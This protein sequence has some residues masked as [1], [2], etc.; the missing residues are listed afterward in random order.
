MFVPNQQFTADLSFVNTLPGRGAEVGKWLKWIVFSPSRRQTHG[1]NAT[2]VGDVRDSIQRA[3]VADNQ[4]KPM[5]EKK[6]PGKG[7]TPASPKPARAA[8]RRIRRAKVRGLATG[9]R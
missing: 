1:W 8:P 7:P 5:T 3:A 4:K 9:K 2:C 6:T